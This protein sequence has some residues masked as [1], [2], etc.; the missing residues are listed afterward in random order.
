MRESNGRNE[1]VVQQIQTEVAVTCAVTS[2]HHADHIQHTDLCDQINRVI[3]VWIHSFD[4]VCANT[5][6]E[7]YFICKFLPISTSRSVNQN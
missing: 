7:S 4:T 3:W 5:A 6:I 1:P 2:Q